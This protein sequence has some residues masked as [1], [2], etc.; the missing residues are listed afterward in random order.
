MAGLASPKYYREQNRMAK[1]AK[2]RKQRIQAGLPVRRFPHLNAG[3]SRSARPMSFSVTITHE[4]DTPPVMHTPK[5]LLEVRV[6]P[7]V[8]AKSVVFPRDIVLDNAGH[9]IVLWFGDDGQVI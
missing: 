5:P 3:S 8:R 7:S 1:E 6:M 9:P 4:R 2:R